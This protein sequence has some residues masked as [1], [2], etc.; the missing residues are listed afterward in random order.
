MKRKLHILTLAL[1]FFSLSN[2][3]AQL[4]PGQEP[5]GKSWADSFQA[6]GLCW[7]DSTF[8]HDLNDINKVSYVINGAKRNIKNIC[9]E[10]KNHPLVRNYRSGDPIYNDIQCGN[11]PANTA[12]DETQC[13]GRVDLGRNGCSE[14]GPKWDV[15]W[16][17]SRP[18][19]G[20]GGTVNQLFENGTYYIES[21]SLNERLITSAASN[22]N[23]EM[24]DEF[25]SDQQVW[26][27]LHLENNVYTIRNKE[28]NR[29]L[30]VPRAICE[31]QANVGT[32]TSAS[33]S[34]QKWEII[35]N[36]SA[37]HLKPLHCADKSLDRVQG[38]SKANVVIENS[39]LSNANQKWTI[40][41]TTSNPTPTNGEE[42][43]ILGESINKYANI[44]S[45][46]PNYVTANSANNF[47]SFTMEP[48]GGNKY[49]FKGENGKYLSSE[50]GAKS[51]TCNRESTGSWEI[52]TVESL[53]G[54]VYTI[55]G[56]N[57]LYLSHEN[58]NK[59]M[60]CNRP[61]AGSW[62]RFIIKDV[63]SSKI[64]STVDNVSSFQLNR[65]PVSNEDILSINVNLTSSADAIAQLYNIQG[66]LIAQQKFS[67]LDAGTNLITL[68]EFQR[69]ANQ[70]GAYILRFIANGNTY[71]KTVVFN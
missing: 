1:I 24:D 31:D 28:T 32:W 51:V 33:N 70:N 19:F 15:A 36:G 7:C 3:S 49:A 44:S 61:K 54:D 45:S 26:T 41:S 47:S 71:S 8:D 46:S 4:P 57:E 67:K 6:N 65:N 48:K 42:V 20:G 55:K 39:S 62:E 13:P 59:A 12:I 63:V 68:K 43:N 30:E 16:L 38:G 9:D 50:D 37:Y 40:V 17:A 23:G 58:G 53:G 29:Y 21:P 60:N 35:E 64:T 10:L 52:F 18:R 34:H 5:G 27:F 14:I 69:A 25:T 56:S 66:K 22:H 11:G 2:I